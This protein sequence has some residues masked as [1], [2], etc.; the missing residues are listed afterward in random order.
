MKFKM[1][2][3]S[4]ALAC[5]SL[6]Y[7]Q[8]TTEYSLSR[9]LDVIKAN[10]AYARG[11]TG[12]GSV[13]AI[14]DTGIDTSSD[15]FKNKILAIKDFSNSGTIVDKVGHGTH[16]AGIAAAAKN[17]VGVQ[18]VAYDASLIVGKITNTGA[19][20]TQT[21]LT[22]ASWAASLGADVANMSVTF[23]I[24]RNT[25]TP[26]LIAPGIYK[27]SYTNT[28]KLPYDFD[29]KAWAAATKGEMIM[30]VAAGNEATA[31]S[32]SITQLATATDANGNLLLGGR[33]IIAGNW[34]SVTNKTVGPSTNGAAHLCQVMVNSVC[35]DKYKAYDFF[36]MAPGTSIISTGLKTPINP[37]G[38]VTMSG[39]SM[40]APAIS[41]G[42]ALIHQM[43][44]QMTGSN[45]VRLLLVT[46]NKNLPGYSLYTMG[47]GLMDLDKATSPVG[48]VGIPTT[49]RLSDTTLASARPLVY[50]ATGSASTGKL[51]G[52]MVVDSFE[53]DFYLNGKSFTAHKKAD[54][55][56]P[57]QAM[58]PYES[59]NPY[60]LFNTY[61]DRTNVQIGSYEMSIYRDTT[62]M[63]E[64]SPMMLEMAYTKNFGDTSVK[65]SGGFFNE[66]NTWL[67][68]SVGSFVGDGKNNNSTTQFAGVEL[69]KAF[70]TGTNLYANFIHG[71]TKTNSH[72]ENIQK[73]GS[74]LSYAWTAGIEQKL[75]INNTIGVMVYQ[76]VSVYRANA[77]LVA[78]VGL[79]SSFNVIQNSSVN[80][81]ADVHEF[82]TGV[83]HKFQNSKEFNT[84]A[85]VEA[86]Q[87]YRG[88][89]GQNDMAVG[90]K[91]TKTF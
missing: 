50:T 4:V 30:V 31:W 85:F 66:T 14:L 55:F 54:P 42:A 1:L 86:R 52:I 40:A 11:Y 48:S 47:Q 34:N 67:G 6:S 58:M 60:T 26:V 83:Y 18:G 37:T 59:H 3:A 23:P 71:I 22:A 2:A 10:A 24:S 49:G 32:N 27:T 64:T 16:V 77:D 28:G 13:I 41:G 70:D 7:A 82:R 75:N 35:Q 29:A 80:L 51:S 9:S 39:T 20:N 21:V 78:P 8:T 53:R 17:G 56:N 62:N 79:D 73:I 45:I 46:A 89:L 19:M 65:F 61:Y 72:S 33:M 91:L 57:H 76:P 84:M 90:F 74:V 38:L 25:I 87:N 36:L 5:S 68:N 63:L 44:P 88:Q 15:E 69:N 81:A 43:W 12:K